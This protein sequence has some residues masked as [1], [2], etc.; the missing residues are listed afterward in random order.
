VTA[1]GAGEDMQLLTDAQ[2]MALLAQ[3]S[4]PMQAAA[5]AATPAVPRAPEDAA[6]AIA[7]GLRAFAAGDAT[8]ALA[9]FTSALE[10][11]GSGVRRMKGSARELSQGEEQAALFNAACCHA[12]LG[13]A[14]AGL[15]C[16]QLCV[17]AGFDDYNALRSDTDLAPLRSSPE[18]A[19][20]A[21]SFPPPS[22]G[23]FGGFFG[24]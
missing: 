5:S 2:M 15:E 20:F 4:P 22:K 9:L 10:L 24:R 12:R 14:V 13:N 11:P 23:L 6:A 1:F 21:A 16:L 19:R 17:R 3:A 8:A 7:A 18:W